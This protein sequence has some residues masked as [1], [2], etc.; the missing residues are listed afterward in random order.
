MNKVIF[1]LILI[2]TTIVVVVVVFVAIIII[3]ILVVIVLGRFWEDDFLF[4]M[5]RL[6]SE[7]HTLI[8]LRQGGQLLRRSRK[9]NPTTRPCLHFV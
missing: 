3:I 9:R 6:I 4:H 2:T 8:K 5:V 7:G 1:I